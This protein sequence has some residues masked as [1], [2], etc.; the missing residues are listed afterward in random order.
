VRLFGHELRILDETATAFHVSL[1]AAMH[2]VGTPQPLEDLRR[3]LRRFEPAVWHAAADLARRLDSAAAFAVGLRLVP[4]G[5]ALAAAL[6]LPTQAPLDVVLAATTPPRG[7]RTLQR[8]SS[9]P[10]VRA[11]ARVVARWL[12]PAPSHVRGS[13]ALARRGAAGLA[14]AY[15]VRLATVFRLL[16]PAFL[17]RRRIVR[18]QRP[19]RAP[20]T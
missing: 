8:V 2:G 1:H 13:S 18:Q 17:A 7:A 20:R 4:E 12:V 6:D 14:A 3:A 9:V 11:K 19:P 10:G 15:V 5:H 16:G